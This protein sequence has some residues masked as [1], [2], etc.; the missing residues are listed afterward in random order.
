MAITAKI[1]TV[2]VLGVRD[3]I[4]NISKTNQE[5]ARRLEKG[6]IKAGFFIQR[7]SQQRVPVDTGA[8]KNS[9]Y[10]AKNGSGLSTEVLVGYTQSYAIYVH[11]ILTA[12]HKPPTMAK[13]LEYPVRWNQ[14]N[15]LN[16]IRDELE[17]NPRPIYGTL[18]P[19][20][21]P[22]MKKPP[23][24]ELEKILKR[25]KNALAKALRRFIK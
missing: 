9:A 19:G 18:A 15:I 10:T 13:F 8:L 1:L 21:T 4:R 7:K 22:R 5:M 23:K 12:R 6:L 24:R 17:G 2:K 11:E 16:I 3:I 14:D 20:S 25:A